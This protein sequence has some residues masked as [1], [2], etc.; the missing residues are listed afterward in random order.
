MRKALAGVVL[1]AASSFGAVSTQAASLP[2]LPGPTISA[3]VT[4]CT[5]TPC[6]NDF[7]LSAGVAN[8]PLSQFGHNYTVTQVNLGDS[9][10]YSYTT[11]NTP[12]ELTVGDP[13]SDQ[14]SVATANGSPKVTTSA[15]IVTGVGGI[16]TSSI[17]TY[18][19]EIVP[20]QGQGALTPVTVGLNA[21]GGIS[22]STTSPPSTYDSLNGAKVFAELTIANTFDELAEADY[23]Y[24]CVLADDYCGQTSNSSTSNVE[25]NLGPTSTFSGGFHLVDT[26]LALV[27]DHPYQVFLTAEMSLGSYPGTATAFVDPMFEVPDG[28]TL[29]LS[30]GISNGVPEPATWA[31]MLVGL[32]GLGAVLRRRRATAP[33]L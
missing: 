26:P 25:V 20:D 30:P 21:T 8:Q 1:M 5:T 14:Y 7:A 10:P 33:A 16:V 29:V 6:E 9:P 23:S 28:Y 2:V 11:Q 13:D 24:D 12:G 15:S 22:G 19:F 27:T 32:G 31:M 4:A 3:G 17:L 18:Y